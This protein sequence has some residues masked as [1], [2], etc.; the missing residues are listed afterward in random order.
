MIIISVLNNYCFTVL[1]IM[2]R[3]LNVITKNTIPA[4]MITVPAIRLSFRAVM[5]LS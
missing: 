3:F 1:S 5:K 4:A 2:E